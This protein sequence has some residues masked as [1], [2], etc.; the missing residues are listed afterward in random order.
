MRTPPTEYL[1]HAMSFATEWHTA[2]KRQPRGHLNMLQTF[3]FTH[4]VY[5]TNSLENVTEEDLLRHKFM[6]LSQVGGQ[7][8]GQCPVD[9]AKQD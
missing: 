5:V 2:D 8:A 9:T 1:V 3:E 7:F 4:F 6:T